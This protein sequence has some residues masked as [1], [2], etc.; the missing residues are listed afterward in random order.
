MTEKVPESSPTAS[1]VSDP[2]LLIGDWPCLSCGHNLRTLVGP[3]ARCP[4]CGHEND[5]RDPKPW[6]KKELRRGLR[7][8]Y[9]WPIP[10]IFMGFLGPGGFLLAL[11]PWADLWLRIAGTLVAGY[12]IWLCRRWVKSC[13]SPRWGFTLLVTG[14]AGQWTLVAGGFFC[15]TLMTADS[16][17]GNNKGWL[18]ALAFVS[19]VVGF[20]IVIWTNQQLMP[21]SK[22]ADRLPPPPGVIPP[23][24]GGKSL[25]LNP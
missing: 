12:W 6:L 23:V 9:D 14:H 25:Y 22:W 1:A 17:P 2:W 4:E 16:L 8:D 7:I 24:A 19:A 5:L 18:I 10:P 11:G 21:D 20:G 13:P 3:V 15:A